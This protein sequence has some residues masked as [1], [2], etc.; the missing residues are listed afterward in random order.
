[1]KN[2]FLITAFS[3]LCV[4]AQA[5][6]V[7]NEVLYNPPGQDSE[8]FEFIEILNNDFFGVNLN[9]YRMTDAVELDFPDLVL[10]PGEYFV[11]S[12]DSTM[13]QDSF[14]ITAWEW[15]ANFLL[16][17]NAATLV[18]KDTF[19]TTI[20]SV[21][22]DEDIPWPEDVGNGQGHS[23]ELCGSKRDNNQGVN[24]LKSETETD[25][26]IGLDTIFCTPGSKNLVCSPYTND[27]VITEIMYNS[28]DT[29]FDSLEFIEIYN[30]GEDFIYVEGFHISEGFDFTFPSGIELDPG[31]YYLLA[32]DADA[33]ATKF[34][35]DEDYVFQYDGGE[36]S[37]NEAE[38]IVLRDDD[39]L[40]IDRVR[41]EQDLPY[42]VEADGDGYSLELCDP[43]VNNWLPLAWKKS[44]HYVQF[45]INNEEVFCTPGAPNSVDCLTADT[46]VYVLDDSFVA[47]NILIYQGETVRW[48]YNG[49]GL[50]N[51]NG[52]PHFTSGEP[53][54]G[55]WNYT[56]TFDEPPA[57]YA[58]QT[59][60]PGGATGVVTVTTPPY[61]DIVIT[62]IL[63][64]QP[65]GENGF[66][67]VEF[68]NRSD[69][70]V[71]L[72]DYFFA[73]GVDYNFPNIGMDPGEYLVITKDAEAFF[74]AF[75]VDAY[76]WDNGGLNNDGETIQLSNGVALVD[77]ITFDD[78]APW[79]EIADGEGASMMLCDITSQN[80][81]PFNW[82]FST[83]Q[84]SVATGTNPNLYIYA[85]P[86]APNDP[87][88]DVPYIFFGEEIPAEVPESVDSITLK[89]KM[90]NLGTGVEGL[91]D[92]VVEG[93]S[94][95]VLDTDFYV[96]EMFVDFND[97]GF[98]TTTIGRLKI[99]IEDD[100]EQELTEKIVISLTNPIGAM[101]AS[102]GTISINIVDND[103]FNSNLYP[104]YTIEEVTT[105]DGNFVTDSLGIPAALT[106]IV[107]GN[108]LHPDGLEFTLID[109][110]D[111]EDGINVFKNNNPTDYTVQ[112]GDE[113]TVYGVIAQH[114]GLTQ[115]IPDTIVLHS[116]NNDLFVPDVVTLLDESTESKL[117]KIE[118][119]QVV[120]V[121][122][123]GPA[124][125]YIV[126]DD[127]NNQYL[128][129]LDDD[130]NVSTADLPPY[131]SA[132]GIG[133]QIDPGDPPFSAGYLFMPRYIED[134]MELVSTT[135]PEDILKVN[136]FPNPT[137]GRLQVFAKAPIETLAVYNMLGEVLLSK[138]IDSDQAQL[139][140]SALAPGCY[141]LSCTNDRHARTI[142]FV[143]D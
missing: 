1:M 104:P 13:M 114:N 106:G 129:R 25:V 87:C 120:D 125:H 41:Y 98:G 62:E 19:G 90:A 57:T 128:M 2:T 64:H 17:N 91:V 18:L 9:A 84:T 36:L 29:D 28:P 5:Q 6:L 85:T 49:T 26:V 133:S 51:I 83:T 44:R 70:I 79:P 12:S 33:L 23:M 92:V 110:L 96:P 67:F 47:E 45:Q 140:V 77:E 137:T 93:A 131:F 15:P 94:T 134:I 48:E 80:D 117:I 4:L 74:D 78:S 40:L 126:V 59:D 81:S 112:E 61:S 22:Y 37:N 141:L 111:K 138:D 63:Y 127:N 122:N 130:I 100:A 34:N 3:F 119:L 30:A 32:M 21:S 139:D 89:F 27:L 53:A 82:R 52:L 31:K 35:I 121:Q 58:Y 118:F 14:G 42:A 56:H 8:A 75:G 123:V 107:Y 136:V 97:G 115:I 86:G 39:G 54:P 88:A 16:N 103:G 10:Q 108:N 101:L 24:W 76:E 55:P 95:A 7:I 143:K 142:R 135:E 116:Q 124:V 71:D 113:V 69:K 65:G 72:G 38:D 109:A 50:H 46:I 66:D 102:T 132:V 68:Y 105:V 60:G 99:F 43:A 11:I 20:D 73:D